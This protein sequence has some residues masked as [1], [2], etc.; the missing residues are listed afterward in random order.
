[1]K[2]MN[3]NSVNQMMQRYW[4]NSNAANARAIRNLASG[5]KINSAADNAAGLAIARRM[6]AQIT[7]LGTA[8]RNAQ[9]TVSMLQTADGVLGS[10]NEVVGRMNELAMRAGNGI[11]STDE[12]KML[13]AEYDQLTAEVDR[14]G[15][16]TNFNGNR[17]FDNSSYTMQVGASAGETMEISMGNISAASLGLD[18]V[19]LTTTEGAGKALNT[20]KNA[21]QIISS[22]RGDIGAS[23]NRLQ[24]LMDNLS[25]GEVNMAESLSKIM[26][27]DFGYETM[28]RSI[29]NV[30]NMTSI[31]MMKNAS[32]LM[33]YNTM[34][35][36]M[37]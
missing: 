8:G 17:L 12:R 11:L 9:D 25:N 7:G 21:T 33:S 10:V 37:R 14:I 2:V 18:K 24:H 3:H 34:Q 4:A 31:S 20:I 28:N 1:M 27:A 22:Q 19:D 5:Y 23:E 29:S 30:L 35:L 36:L 16:N 15:E 6:T 26:D 32:Y 13:Q